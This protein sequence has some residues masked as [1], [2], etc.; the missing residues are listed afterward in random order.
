[1]QM[2]RQRKSPSAA[3]LDQRD[4]CALRALHARASC[5]IGRDCQISHLFGALALYLA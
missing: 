1:M 5:A 3:A 4:G 2:Q